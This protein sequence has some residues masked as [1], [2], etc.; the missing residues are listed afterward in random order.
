MTINDSVRNQL[1]SALQV[2]TS[3]EA[4]RWL[5]DALREA[6]T[7]SLERLLAIYTGA[8]MRLGRLPLSAPGGESFTDTPEGLAL[9]R[10]TLEDAARATFL[11]AR[12]DHEA[13]ER[14]AADARACFEMGDAREQQSWLRAAVLLPAPDQF[15]PLVVDACRTNI[16]PLFEAVACENPYPSRYFPERNFNQLVM[17]ALFNGVRLE[18]IFG[19]AARANTELARMATDF[20]AER[21]AAGR[22]VPADIG[23][24]L[25][26]AAA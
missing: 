20:A 24:A 26:S 9:D 7:G 16:L 19:L 21:R 15:L 6:Q 5:Q 18:R 11:L 23:L 3:G 2:R 8:S 25:S 10:W 12:A 4:A 13:P 14:F 22:T 1:Q 17:K